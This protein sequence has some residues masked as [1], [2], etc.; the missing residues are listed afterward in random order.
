MGYT[1]SLAAECQPLRMSLK[2]KTSRQPPDS[3]CSDATSRCRGATVR[4]VDHS[5][6]ANFSWSVSELFKTV[7]KFKPFE[8][9][10]TRNDTN[11]DIPRNYPS[12]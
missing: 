4:R 9:R 10:R 5:T 1:F 2:K 7:R 8:I 3:R 11:G 12:L 6:R